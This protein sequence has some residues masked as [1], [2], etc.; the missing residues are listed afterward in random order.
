MQYA[1]NSLNELVNARNPN[2]PDVFVLPCDGQTLYVHISP[3]VWTR[4][5]DGRE[6]TAF[7]IGLA[8]G[9]PNACRMFGK[10]GT[11]IQENYKNFQLDSMMDYHII[12]SIMKNQKKF[13]L[14]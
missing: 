14:K 5:W 9:C 11:F 12:E 2:V 3:Y 8:P 6:H 13:Q 7:S 1:S 10:I 4:P